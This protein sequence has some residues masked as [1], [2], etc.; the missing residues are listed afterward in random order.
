MDFVFCVIELQL[1]RVNF[2]RGLGTRH[3]CPS[4]SVVNM[5][6]LYKNSLSEENSVTSYLQVEE[7][8]NPKLTMGGQMEVYFTRDLLPLGLVEELSN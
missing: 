2:V 6:P 4:K 1:G 8:S 5:S 3:F 7:F